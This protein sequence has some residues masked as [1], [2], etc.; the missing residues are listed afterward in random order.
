M[1]LDKDTREYFYKYSHLNK[2]INKVLKSQ[3]ILEKYLDMCPNTYLSWSCGKDSTAVLSLLRAIDKDEKIPVIHFDLGVELPNTDSYKA[4]F[5]NITTF[6]PS[7][8][9]IETMLE[10]G[11][12][13]KECRKSNFIKEFTD[14]NKFDGHIMGL[15]Y[16]ESS[17]R[18]NLFKRGSIYKREEDDM[19]VCNPIYNWDFEDVFAYLI[20]SCVPIHPHYSIKSNQPLE[21]RRVGGYVSGR[22]RGSEFGRFYWFKEQ[23]PKEFYELSNKFKE[24]NNYV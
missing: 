18:R 13:S 24:I 23:Y 19:W 4:N 14:N 11:F 10:F 3:E 22:N 15:R 1:F 2:H 16:N 20:S 9:L 21:E 12:E 8:N 17:A 7:K 5:T 6:K